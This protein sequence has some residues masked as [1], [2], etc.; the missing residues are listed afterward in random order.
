[1]KFTTRALWTLCCALSSGLVTGDALAQAYPS[2]PIRVVAPFAPGG[3]TDITARLMANQLAA[4][5]GQ[6]V[7]IENKPGANTA[8]GAEFVAR[9]AADGY[10]LLF[11]N[12]QTF[13]LN[14]LLFAKLSYDPVRDFTPVASTS[15]LPLTLVVATNLPVNSL[16]EL[17]AYTQAR[18]GQL[19]YGS[20]GVGSQA[21]IMG[22]MYKKLTGTDLV[23]VAYKGSAP[24]VADVAGGQVV[25]TFPGIPTIQGFLKGGKLKVL[26]LSGDKRNPLLPDV[27]TFTEAGYKGLDIGAWYGY[28]APAGT[29]REVIMKLNQTVASIISDREFVDKSLITAGMVP[30]QTTPEQFTAF[31]RS[32][33]ER[34]GA[35]IRESGAKA[36]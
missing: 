23:H 35:I 12:D 19:S 5:L 28:V 22:E 18:K 32:E 20:Y 14:S 8:I 15:Y 1:M 6:Q 30:M 3:A 11:S 4:K 9:S 36:E 26:A 31:M 25:F 27:P 13:V 16:R 17:V 2:R 33:T 24:A 34:M 21:H 10:T 7:I 29:P